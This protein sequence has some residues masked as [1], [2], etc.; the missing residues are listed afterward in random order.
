MLVEYGIVRKPFIGCGWLQRI[1]RRRVLME[2]R[3]ITTWE[4]QAMRLSKSQGL[5][6]VAAVNDSCSSLPPSRPFVVCM[7]RGDGSRWVCAGRSSQRWTPV[8]RRVPSER[9]AASRGARSDTGGRRPAL[10]GPV[11]VAAQV[12]SVV[13]HQ[14]TRCPVRRIVGGRPGAARWGLAH[15]PQ[16]GDRLTATTWARQGRAERENPPGLPGAPP[17]RFP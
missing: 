2:P 6:N 5:S 16:P 12:L 17:R 1:P 8:C 14:A 7:G 15:Q 10:G 4:P 3:S 13:D 11:P 9:S